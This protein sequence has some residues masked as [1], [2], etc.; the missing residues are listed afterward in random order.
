M[1]RA[2]KIASS[3]IGPGGWKCHCCAPAPGIGV[4]LLKR[5]AK[6]KDHRAAMREAVEDVR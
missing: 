2:N 5:A 6:K 1:N 4:R 3:H